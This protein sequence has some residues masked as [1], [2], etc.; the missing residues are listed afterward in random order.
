MDVAAVKDPMFNGHVEPMNVS[1]DVAMGR[2]PAAPP[3]APAA[4]AA[5]AVRGPNA[6]ARA[7][8]AVPAAQG[9]PAAPVARP[10]PAQEPSAARA[11]FTAIPTAA[12]VVPERA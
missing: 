7:L 10:A 12:P 6:V 8:G 11:A 1:S 3:P 5:P 2:R 9:A 4:V